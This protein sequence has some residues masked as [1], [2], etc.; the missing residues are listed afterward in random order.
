MLNRETETVF[1]KSEVSKSNLMADPNF[2][3][4]SG[5]LD[6]GPYVENIYFK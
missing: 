6:S 3:G 1:C 5:Y 4:I 2:L